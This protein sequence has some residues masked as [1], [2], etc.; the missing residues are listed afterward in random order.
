VIE[1]FPHFNAF[2][3]RDQNTVRDFV[4]QFAPYSDFNTTSLFVWDSQNTAKVCWLNGNLVF[5]FPDYVSHEYL[6]TFLGKNKLKE[7][8]E[9][10]LARA[11]SEGVILHLKLI[12]QQVIEEL[13][14]T[15]HPFHVYEDPDN[16]DYILSVEEHASLPGKRYK[17]KRNMVR[18]FERE[19][20]HRNIELREMDL[21]DVQTKEKAHG[22]FHRW[23]RLKQKTEEDI[24]NELGAFTKFLKHA[25]HFTVHS[26]GLF[27]DGTLEAFAFHEPI[28]EEHVV[29]HFEKT[30]PGYVGISSYFEHHYCQ[31]LR[32]LG[33]KLI[34][35]EQD[36]G[37]EGLKLAKRLQKPTHL[38]KKYCIA[39]PQAAEVV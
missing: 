5:R 35:Y 36:M 17:K 38:L 26:F 8:V 1:D 24:K 14:K 20:G 16:H 3:L 39:L 12:P 23:A 31:K 25:E 33:K 29:T 18:R 34:N 19:Y 21:C 37:N 27:I 10:L 7:T 22:L 11:K 2:T 6:Y 9:T 28:G 13:E 30:N 32:D 15:N 4:D